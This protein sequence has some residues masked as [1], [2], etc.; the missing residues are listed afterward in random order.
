MDTRTI[1]YIRT[2]ANGNGGYIAAYD[3][4]KPDGTVVAHL[5]VAHDGGVLAEVAVFAPFGR[6]SF[7]TLD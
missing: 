7:I 4:I 3:G 1:L 6:Q 2:V 5:D